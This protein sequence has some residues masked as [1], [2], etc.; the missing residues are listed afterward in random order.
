SPITASGAIVPVLVGLATG[1]RPGPVQ[2]AGIPVVLVGIV[3]AARRPAAP[4]A[5]AGSS[6]APAGRGL[7]WA[8]LAALLFGVFL[9]TYAEAAADSS[10]GALL[11]SR[12]ALLT[13]TA[14]GVLVLRAPC[15]CVPA[16]AR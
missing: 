14:V 7:G 10:P 3:L 8:L 1:D 9:A 5:E 11:W 2:L 6:A 16:T 15:A 12:V 13:S 4:A